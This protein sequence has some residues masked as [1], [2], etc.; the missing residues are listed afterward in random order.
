MARIQSSIF[1]ALPWMDQDNLNQTSSLI[2]IVDMIKGFMEAGN[3]ADPKIAETIP[4][5][6]Q[7][8][9]ALPL[10]DHLYFV[11]AHLKGCQ[12][13]LS[14][15]EHC[16]KGSQESEI[17]DELKEDSLHSKIIYKNSTNGFLAP[18]FIN[19][20]EE[21]MRY[22]RFIITGCCS[23]ICV[24]QFTLS[25]QTYI[26]EHDL[27]KQV[28]VVMDAIDTYH[29]EGIHDAKRFNEVSY[30]LLNAAGVRFVKMKE[31]TK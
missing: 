11:D 10:A 14:F 18:D 30:Q 15:P 2:V 25:L 8:F 29:I 13:F 9:K 26:H 31:G 6:L 3:M 12:E 24:L 21:Y 20:L 4:A 22:E 16:L 27:N 28:Y 5:H 23:D 19:H 17:A 1:E 7:L